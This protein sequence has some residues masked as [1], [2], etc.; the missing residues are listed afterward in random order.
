MTKKLFL[1]A[2]LVAGLLLV[3]ALF[4]FKILGRLAPGS[5]Q[6]SASPKATVV[7][8][9]V[10][11]GVTPFLDDAMAQGEH[12][13]KLVAEGESGLS[14]EGR[15]KIN[16]GARTVVNRRMSAEGENYS[17]GEVLTLEKTDVKDKATLAV[18]S[19]P[20]QAVVKIDGQP[21][22]FAPVS[23]K[24]LAADDYQ[25]SVALPGYEEKLLSAH[26]AVGYRLIMNVQLA[27]KTEGIQVGA[28]GI[29]T[30]TPTQ[31][32]TA[33]DQ[34]LGVKI[35]KPYVTIKETPTGF[36]RVREAPSGREVAQIEPKKSFPFIEKNESGWYKIEY[37]QDKQGW[38]SS[39]YADL[40]E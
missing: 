22:G 25:V 16:S 4:K 17:S 1:G 23:L 32:A 21:K 28:T 38:I 11:R 14:W 6:I 36:L 12:D 24:N 13:L 27:Q 30:P 33:E 5:L 19:I 37:G 26:T 2:G 31:A 8:D 20:D 9:G 29:L 18:V 3:G 15:I 34:S 7:I 35:E 10:E 39:V 40:I